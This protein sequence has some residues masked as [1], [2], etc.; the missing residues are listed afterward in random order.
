MQLESS[1]AVTDDSPPPLPN[2]NDDGLADG[3]PGDFPDCVT[4]T[5]VPPISTVPVRSAQDGFARTLTV[6]QSPPDT[7]EDVPIHPRSSLTA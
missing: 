4:G 2:V 1:P 5:G 6:T 3:G 7:L